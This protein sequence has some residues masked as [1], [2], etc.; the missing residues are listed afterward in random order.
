[1]IYEISTYPAQ[2][3]LREAEPI[4]DIT[5]DV[6]K[7]AQ[8][9]VETMYAKQGIGLAAPQVGQGCRLIT[10]DIS[11]PESRTDLKVVV[12]PTI[13]QA[14]GETECE[15]GCLS[16][17]EFKVK[18][19]RSAKV[20]VQGQDLEGHPLHIQADGLLAICLQHEIDHLQGTLLLDHA[21]RLKRNMYEKKV[22]KWQRSTT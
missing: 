13:V 5:E 7:L 8:D 4:E 22:R 18:T 17:P 15:E 14:E 21:G 16:L 11:G 9:M 2:V 1:M 20:E 6:H 19:Q 12:N 3:L 10:V